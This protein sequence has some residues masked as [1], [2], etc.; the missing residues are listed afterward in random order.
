MSWTMDSNWLWHESDERKPHWCGHRE[1]YFLQEI[2]ALG[3]KQFFQKFYYIL[4][5]AK[6]GDNFAE[7]ACHLFYVQVQHYTFSSC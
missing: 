1:D 4:G 6:P 2:K 7:A 3:W 5:T